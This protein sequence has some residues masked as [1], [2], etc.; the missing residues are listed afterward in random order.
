VVHESFSA[1]AG[2]EEQVTRLELG[3]RDRDAGVALVGRVAG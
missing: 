1:T 3:E 2:E